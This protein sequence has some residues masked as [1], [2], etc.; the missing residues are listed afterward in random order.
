MKILSTADIHYHKDYLKSFRKS[1]AFF[2]EIAEAEQPDLITL[3]GDTA[4]R[5]INN[6]ESSA[7]P[8][9]LDF[10]TALMNIAPVVTVDG[11]KSHDIPGSLGVFPRMKARYGFIILQPGECTYLFTNGMLKSYPIFEDH[12][13]ELADPIA[14][15]YGIPEPNKSWLVAGTDLTGQDARNEASIQLTALFQLIAG[16]AAALTIPTIGIFHGVVKGCKISETQV[17]PEGSIDVTAAT[18]SALNLSYI[19]CGHIHMRQ[20]LAPKIWYEG[21]FFPKTWGERDQ[22]SFS[23]VKIGSGGTYVS[24][25]PFPH[26]PM[27]K[28]NKHFDEIQQVTEEEVRGNRVW[29]EVRIEANRRSEMDASLILL[30]LQDTLGAAAGSRVSSKII[31]AETVRAPEILNSRDLA[32]KFKLWHGS[33]S[34]LKDITPLDIEH[35]DEVKEMIRNEG[36]EHEQKR[37][38]L[39]KVFI[40]GAEGIIRGQ[41]KEELTIDF[42]DFD[43]GIIA[44]LGDNGAGKSTFIELCS[45]YASPINPKYTK[46]QDLF[47][48]RDS[49]CVKEWT[50]MITGIRYETKWLIDGKNASGSGE[51]YLSIQH[52]GGEFEPIHSGVTGLKKPYEAA[53]YQIFGSPEMYSRSAYIAQGNIDLPTTPKGRKELFNELLG[54]DYLE[55][56]FAFSKNKADELQAAVEKVQTKIAALQDII[57]SNVSLETLQQDIAQSTKF[58]NAT[59][60]QKEKYA[61]QIILY[62]GKVKKVQDQSIINSRLHQEI[63]SLNEEILSLKRKR[64]DAEE[65]IKDIEN[66]REHLQEAKDLIFEADKTKKLIEQKNAELAEIGTKNNEI[67]R[68][69]LKMEQDH[70]L[71]N[72]NAAEKIQTNQRETTRLKDLIAFGKREILSNSE[73]MAVYADPCEKC[74]WIKDENQAKIDL[75]KADSEKREA[76]QVDAEFKLMGLIGM[77]VKLDIDLEK[78]KPK[79]PLDPLPTTDI[80]QERINL[81]ATLPLTSNYEK[82]NQ[83]IKRCETGESQLPLY[84]KQVSENNKDIGNKMLLIEQDTAAIKLPTE[85]ELQAEPNLYKY[86]ELVNLADESIR[87]TELEINSAQLKIENI[88]QIK[89]Q[90]TE[91][92]Q[93]IKKDLE[94]VSSWRLLQK[95]LSRDG[96][97]ALELDALAPSIADEAN[98][99]LEDA[100]GP[101]FSLRFQTTKDVGTGAAA[102]QAEDFEIYITDNELDI[103]DL[104]KEQKLST[105]SGGE[106]IWILKSLYDAFGI[107]REKNTGLCYVTTFQDEA[108]GALSPEKKHLY[109]QMVNKAHRA[110]E[111]F[112]TLYITH[113]LTIQ[114][115]L[116][117]QII[118]EKV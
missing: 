29:L 1:A 102:H 43:Q 105:L 53:A 37:I 93:W 86:K 57:D 78:I 23:R 82:A 42:R 117:Q 54:N 44:L 111:R 55:V 46:M 56:A 69:N 73:M 35:L 26:P 108:D 76:E 112:H 45:P 90:I 41:K 81:Q 84:V 22:K 51:Y 15:I 34:G 70:Y 92:S 88:R 67:D 80:K 40:R 47:Y 16:H 106:R 71:L 107:T 62:T 5:V 91:K 14:A 33:T 32:E 10:I 28:I 96:I 3:A 103:P 27:V 83:T 31:N 30:Q 25:I 115:S 65:T 98:A 79:K 87:E 97:Q 75:L 58:L 113:D 94:D 114:K 13:T 63:A 6:S 64:A 21:S 95:G 77:K 48:L 12:R 18:L 24:E 17:L 60:G 36:F 116:E 110:A 100:Y 72:K 109:L 59:I 4:D 49:Q 7:M 74:G 19:S 61:A 68:K 11:T 2:V 8:E 39:D 118:F 38:R 66:M 99:L 101:K 85:E 104:D 20:E 9:L 50:D 89:T 52:P